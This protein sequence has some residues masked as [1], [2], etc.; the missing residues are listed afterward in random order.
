MA[1]FYVLH[2]RE[3]D[4]SDCLDA[5]RFLSDP[6]EKQRAHITLRG[7]YQKKID[8]K[9]INERIA[10]RIVSID[11]VGNFFSSNQNTVFFQCSAP[12]F[13]AVWH[14]EDFPFNPHLT[15]YDGRSSE[16]AHR[17]YEL[18]SPY[19][20]SLRFRAEQLDAIQSRR[21][22][23]S[24]TLAISFNSELVRRIVGEKIT[25]AQVPK[26]TSERR[27]ELIQQLCKYLA[28]LAGKGNRHR[29]NH[30]ASLPFASHRASLPN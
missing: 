12:V 29:E 11:G 22:Q 21:G 24:F 4:L 27:L 19:R 2:V 28:T 6:A 16:F 20:Y 17:L 8:V 5:I 3:R 13:R 9:A 14:K 1:V 15:I 23:S 25:A 7:P 30:Q 10:G 18:V 26:L